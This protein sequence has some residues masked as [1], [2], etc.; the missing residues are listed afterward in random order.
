METIETKIKLEEFK[1]FALYETYYQLMM[2]LD[3]SNVA[4]KH[5]NWLMNYHFRKV[6]GKQ[7][8]NNIYEIEN[9]IYKCIATLKSN[10]VT[11]KIL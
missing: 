6:Y 3:I 9:E 2:C 1:A 8:N 10:N 7:Y 4:K 11:Q 5:L